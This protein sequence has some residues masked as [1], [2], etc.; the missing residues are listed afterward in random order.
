MFQAIALL[1]VAKAAVTTPS[2]DMPF[3][4]TE[5]CVDASDATHPSNKRL[6]FVAEPEGTP[7]AAGWPV[8]FSLV[9][10]VY[11]SSKGNDNCYGS[12]TY[13]PEKKYSAFVS[14]A[15]SLDFCPCIKNNTCTPEARGKGTLKK[16]RGT[17]REGEAWPPWP[18]HHYRCD[19][20]DLAGILW[21]Q[22]L[23]QF[24]L[25]NGFAVVQVNPMEDDSWDAWD[26]DPQHTWT[27]GN[28]KPWLQKV[29][30]ML[31]AGNFG[32]LDPK[33]I[34]VRGWSGGAQMVSW[35]FNMAPTGV[36]PDVEFI[37]GVFLAGGSHNCYESLPNVTHGICKTCDPS[38][39]C[40]GSQWH[41]NAGCSSN[42][43]HRPCCA[44]CCPTNFTEQYYFDHPDQY[45]KHPPSFLA[46]L[47]TQDENADL[48][49]CKNY[50]NTLQAYGVYSELN[51]VSPEYEKCYCIGNPQDPAAQG[52]PYSQYCT[53]SMSW[54]CETH[55]MGFAQM[56]APV[57]Q[58]MLNV[59]QNKTNNV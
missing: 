15:D 40:P 13:G 47:T 43:T 10:D 21:D 8:Y 20:D 58:F 26:D 22:R 14:P 4:D 30:S 25:A 31:A 52:S 54:S 36:F 17:K 53:D 33:S 27:N 57:T 37:G 45:S 2:W 41:V 6:V 59:V 3:T 46:Q 35:L 12:S 11:P 32:K 51:L 23:K 24:M 38:D 7:P 16:N 18:P 55:T 29:F 1:S 49:A 28:D 48:C 56:V 39:S 44:K 50:Y 5:T 34:F 42:M 9:T 19:Y